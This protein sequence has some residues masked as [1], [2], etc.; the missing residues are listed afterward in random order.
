MRCCQAGAPSSFGVGRATESVFR[1]FV[2]RPGPDPRGCHGVFFRISER[3]AAHDL[4]SSFVTLFAR[5]LLIA[6]GVVAEI[7]GGPF[8]D[9]AREVQNVRTRFAVGILVYVA[10]K[11]ES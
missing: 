3:A 6:A 8:G 7:A 10:R 2:L 9:I 5:G 4:I 1:P 11:I